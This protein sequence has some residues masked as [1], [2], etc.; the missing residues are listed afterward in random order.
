MHGAFASV[1]ECW[2]HKSGFKQTGES[3]TT[4]ERFEGQ[5]ERQIT[6][7]EKKTFHFEERTGIKAYIQL[8]YIQEK[9]EH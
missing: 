3:E 2:W 4:N 5:N 8:V 7:R 9:E 1:S 6:W